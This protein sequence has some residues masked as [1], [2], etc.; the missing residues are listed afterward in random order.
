[1]GTD[2]ACNLVEQLSLV[3][4]SKGR[5]LL[6][7]MVDDLTKEVVAWLAAFDAADRKSRGGP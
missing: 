2:F 6:A 7:A 4:L 5:T 1:M 3:T